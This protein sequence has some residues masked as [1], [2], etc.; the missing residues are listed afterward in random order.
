MIT[1]T[2]T[3]CRA[4]LEMDDGFAGGA[5]RCQH[6]GTIQTVP[7]RLKLKSAEPVKTRTLYKN[8]PDNVS[9][10]S[11]GLDQLADIVASSGIESGRL[12][13]DDSATKQQKK[14][15]TMLIACA[16]VIGVLSIAL[17]VVLTK[18]SDTTAGPTAPTAVNS[19][20][21]QQQQATAKAT[22]GPPNFCGI[23]LDGE[24]V[25]YVLDRGDSTRDNFGYLKDAA[26]KSAA[27]L[28]P[29]RRFKIV[30]WNN[31]SDDSYPKDYP[32]AATPENVSAAQRAIDEIAAHG[33][34][35]VTSAMKIA[36]A[37]N[38]SDIVI[39]T[40]KAWDLDE[41]FIAAVDRYRGD[42][43][44]RVHTVSLGDPGQSTAL[45]TVAAASRG[46]FKQLSESD[47]K[48]FAR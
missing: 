36:V 10:P 20:A 5:C 40:G 33:K 21:P 15:K 16:S 43:N 2:C 7:S 8:R 12:R 1:L 39:V 28:G 41:S 27:T 6:C 29:D 18:S 24:T 22:N 48:D 3:H 42:K 4:T 25:I 44:I 30:F 37:G 13:K 23:T 14:L 26:L 47:L 35:D 31:G 11:S 45:Q 34:T 9:V 17:I 46:S 38:P 19:I 32:T